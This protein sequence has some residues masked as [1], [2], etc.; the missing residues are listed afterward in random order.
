VQYRPFIDDPASI[1]VQDGERY[2]V[3]RATG[4]VRPIWI[5]I[6]DAVAVRLAG[7][8]A[9]FP[10]EP[11]V[12]LVGIGPGASPADV[13]DIASDW[14]HTVAPLVITTE[15]VRVF[16]APDQ[17][18]LIEVR[19]TAALADA[20]TSLR[21]RVRRRG[22][23]V[24]SHVAPDDWIFHLT[25]AYG[26]RIPAERWSGVAAWVETLDAPAAQTVVDEAEIASFDDGRESSGGI[27]RLVGA[28]EP[29]RIS[30]PGGAPPDPGRV[31]LG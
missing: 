30:P 11:H 15:R 6:R 18:A 27:V 3:L 26:S 24:L 8:D 12:T 2:V 21:E 22:L 10:L 1:P 13:C 23:T 29:G 4:A 7:L 31:A 19:R 16:P 25:L 20:M 28:A 14:A 17:V 5:Q 9:A